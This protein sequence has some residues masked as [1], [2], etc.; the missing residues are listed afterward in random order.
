MKIIVYPYMY[1]WNVHPDM[2]LAHADVYITEMEPEDSKVAVGK[3]ITLEVELFDNTTLM[4]GKLH[5]LEKA[6][7]MVLAEFTQQLEH[8]DERIQQLKALPA[9][10]EHEWFTLPDG[11][12]ECSLCQTPRPAE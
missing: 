10:C 12:E 8:M 9:P 4:L 7:E 6:R 3:P 2:A 11:T 1:E 5:C